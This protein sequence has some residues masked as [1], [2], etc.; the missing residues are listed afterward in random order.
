VHQF[1]INSEN[2]LSGTEDT[3]NNV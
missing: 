2:D 1:S 3:V